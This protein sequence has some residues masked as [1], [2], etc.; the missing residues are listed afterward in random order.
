ME[1]PSAPLEACHQVAK[2]YRAVGE[3]GIREDYIR[4]IRQFHMT[5]VTDS[6]CSLL[7]PW[8]APFL[9][10][11]RSSSKFDC[12]MKDGARTNFLVGISS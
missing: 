9:W 2:G 7:L 4:R 11:I 5:C 6:S 12:D 10:I 1:S 3:G 8:E